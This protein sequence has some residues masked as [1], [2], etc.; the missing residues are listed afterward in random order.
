MR[1]WNLGLGDPLNLTLAADARLGPTNYVD[2]Q[3][4][5]LSLHGGEPPAVILATTFG[6]RARSMRLFPRFIRKGIGVSSPLEFHKPP[7]V[8]NFYPNYLRLSFWP[9]PGI[10][11]QDEYW[12]PV[13]NSVAG[14]FTIHN[15][16]VIKDKFSFEWAGVLS[17]LDEGEGMSLVSVEKNQTLQGKTGSLYPVCVFNTKSIP[18]QGPFPAL[19]FDLEL[20]PGN[21]RQLTWAMAT[22]SDPAASFQA[23]RQVLGRCWDAEIARIELQN[24]N[25]MLEIFTGDEDWDAVFAFTQKA[26]YSLFHSQNTHLSSPSLVLSRQPDDGYSPRG[27]GSDYSFLWNGQTGLD[28]YYLSSLILPGGANLAEGL[29]RN[30]LA[31]QKEDGEVE[32]KPSLSGKLTN[33]MAQ[34]ILAALALEIDQTRSDHSW[35]TEIFPPLLK[36][37]KAWFS[38]QHDRDQDAYPEWDH[39]LQTGLEDNPLYD[40]WSPSAQG[41]EIQSLECPSLAALLYREAYSLEQIALR[42]DS[43][44]EIPWL[45]EKAGQL[46]QQVESC[47]NT[48]EGI[49]NYRDYNT[50]RSSDGSI[51]Y[52]LQGSTAST[53]RCSF[54][55]PQRLIL[56]ITKSNET[57]RSLTVQVTGLTPEGEITEEF[58][59][60]RWAW[61]RDHGSSS[62]QNAFLTIL[63]VESAG[64]EEEDLLTIG[65]V[66]YMQEDISLL[67]PLWAGLPDS[68]R[69]AS[70]VKD[71]LE[72]RFLHF[73]G[74]PDYQFDPGTDSLADIQRVSPI[75]NQ[76]IGE[77]LIR[78]GFRSLAV[79]LVTRLMDAIVPVLCSEGE[80]RQNYHPDSGQPLGE[81]NHLRGLPPLGLFLQAAG[82]RW[83]GKEF[84]ILQDFNGFPWPVTVKYQGMIVTCL[85]DQTTITF[86]NGETVQVTSP[87]VHRISLE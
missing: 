26:A 16:N 5:Q 78:Y 75:W 9:F 21:T 27:D 68:E 76:L 70:L 73:Y 14:R 42:I 62:S 8:M 79:D 25:Q 19:K 47:W 37:F 41:L 67:L 77:G 52:R 29:L 17:P 44:E 34:P 28:S 49:Y 33:H 71:C 7:D 39:P 24:T 15:H 55:T 86:P 46:R 58:P 30:F 3:I 74:L 87:G 64:A 18:A 35:L 63:R 57:T 43:A 38:P 20:F 80:F 65:R 50:H 81:R 2:D 22:L 83:I 69:A 1:L 10:E 82:I 60:R 85:A 36:F 11:V 48:T 23:A 54:K 31:A 72:T 61:L 6:L 4:W 84:V 45:Q 51:L 40:R 66:D 59:P 56:H 12:V 32:W 53:L 13:S